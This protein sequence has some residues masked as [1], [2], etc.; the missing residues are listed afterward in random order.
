MARKGFTD[1]QRAVL[2]KAF[3]ENESLAEKGRKAKLAAE[4][5]LTESQV[6]NW[7]HDHKK[8]RKSKSNS[9]SSANASWDP[10]T[11]NGNATTTPNSSGRTTSS[12]TAASS[13]SKAQSSA[14]VQ[15][16]TQQP[17]AISQVTLTAVTQPQHPVALTAAAGPGGMV[18]TTVVLT[19]FPPPQITLHPYGFRW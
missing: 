8:T 5:G 13:R 18:P 3:E 9:S 14:Q 15:Q 16:Q 6:K 19:A 7:F 4:T 2:R 11:S 10:N 17:P 1:E 12:R